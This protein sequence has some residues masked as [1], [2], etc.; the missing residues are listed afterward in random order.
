MSATLVFRTANDFYQG[1]DPP[2]DLLGK[3]LKSQG[4]CTA[5]SMNWAKK[6]L[7]RGRSVNSFDEIGLN[8]HTL[9]AQMAKLRKLDRDPEQQC[10]LVGLQM[11]SIIG[12]KDLKIASIA[13]VIKLGDDNPSE[14]IIFWTEHHTMAYRYASQNKEFFDIEVGLYRAKTTAEIK[15]KMKEITGP[16][17]ALT[18]ARVVKLKD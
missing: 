14:V 16:Y 8:V 18:G 1:Y 5:A 12:N 15:E 7:N 13:D 10:D 4:I 11:V 3:K 9:N 17:G 2:M 6:V